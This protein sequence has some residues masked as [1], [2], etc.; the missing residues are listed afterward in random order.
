M[1][2]RVPL[3]RLWLGADGTTPLQT[4]DLT[5]AAPIAVSATGGKVAL[6]SGTSSLGCNGAKMGSPH[7]LL[8]K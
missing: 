8:A 3:G 4:P 5:D 2:E 1:S 7:T 6:V